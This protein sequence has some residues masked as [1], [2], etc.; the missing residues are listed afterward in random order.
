MLEI[1]NR[2]ILAFKRRVIRKLV[3][4]SP[5]A[6]FKA[7]QYYRMHKSLLRTQRRKY[8]KKY[9]PFLKH[10]VKSYKPKRPIH[11]APKPHYKKPVIKK[12]HAPK[13]PRKP[14]IP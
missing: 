2:V 14:R 10:K 1:V 7:R 6:R 9:K 3:K 8:T 13:K 4:R 5:V 12:F 11:K